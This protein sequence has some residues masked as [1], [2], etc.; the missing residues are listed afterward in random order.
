MTLRAA[1]GDNEP[2]DARLL[3]QGDRPLVLLWGAKGQ[4]SA[5]PVPRSGPIARKRKAVETAGRALDRMLSLLPPERAATIRARA[6]TTAR[7]ILG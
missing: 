3:V 2:V 4:P 7:R 1:S 6:R 5:I